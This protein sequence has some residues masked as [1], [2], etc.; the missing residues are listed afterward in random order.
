M[1][2]NSSGSESDDVAFITRQFKSFLRKNNKY[3]RKWKKINIAKTLKVLLVL[4]AIN[5]GSLGM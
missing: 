5:A 1:D 2:T 4:F 3:Q